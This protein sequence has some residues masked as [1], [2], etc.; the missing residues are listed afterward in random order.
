MELRQ[1]RYAVTLAEELH[2]GKA[3]ARLAVSQPSI[4]EQ[5]RRLETDLGAELFSRT[6]R[7]VRLTPVGEAF[8]GDARRILAEV[9]RLRNT[10]VE[11]SQGQL[12]Q[13]RIGSVGPA[14]AGIAPMVVK[15]VLRVAPQLTVS[16]EALSTE[17]QIQ[18]ILHGD[19]DAG[20][21]RVVSRRKGLRVEHLMDEPLI[22]VLP[23]DHRLASSASIRLSDLNNE[24]FVVWP[25]E[26]NPNFFDQSIATCH[27]HGCLP[28]KL[29]EGSDIQ[30]QLA[31]ISAGLGVAVLPR[32]FRGSRRDGIAFVPLRGRVRPVPLHLVWSAAHETAAVRCL[33]DVAVRIRP[34]LELQHAE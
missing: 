1:L 12:G 15:E 33:R 29:I 4:S 27:G 2:F 13:L 22:A 30:T 18:A 26:F 11:Y 25:R 9:D 32:S 8:V 16:L 5:I 20:F 34:K 14:L 31:C 7:S 10:V 6:S 3:A 28:S 17:K 21:M 24:P 19:L 23:A